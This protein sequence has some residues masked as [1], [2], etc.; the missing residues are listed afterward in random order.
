MLRDKGNAAALRRQR[1]P[2]SPDVGISTAAD[3]THQPYIFV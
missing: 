3:G 2:R 1:Y